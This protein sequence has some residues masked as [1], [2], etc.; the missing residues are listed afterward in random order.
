MLSLCMI[1]KNEELNL[2]NC[3]NSV[4]DLSPE[5]ILV[6]TGSTDAT[7][8]IAA[9][10]GS[11]IVPFDFTPIDFSAARN[12]ALARA[13]GNWILVLDADE[14]LQPSAVPLLRSLVEANRQAGYFVE[15]INHSPGFTATDHVVRLFPNDPRFRYRGRVHETI[16]AAILASG[17]PLLQTE[18]RIDHRFSADLESRRRKNYWYIEILK[19]ELAANP[20]DDSRL[21]FLAAEYHQLEMYREAAEIAE[22]IARIRPLDAR[23]HLFAGTYHLLFAPDY[24]QARADFNQALKLR[25]SYPEAESFL[26]LLDQKERALLELTPAPSS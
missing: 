2:A 12:Y 7:L 19:Q 10:Y 24:T 15:R 20:D 17:A 16:D 23:A 3:L 1:V 25:P 21:D 18:I 22:Q 4:R 5:L 9:Q 8:S 6:D 26:R 13:N 14:M 11:S